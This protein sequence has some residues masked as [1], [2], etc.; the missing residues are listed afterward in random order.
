MLLSLHK[1]GGE[2]PAVYDNVV[3][4]EETGPITRAGSINEINVCFH[5]GESRLPM[6]DCQ[7][8][9]NSNDS[10]ARKDG[11]PKIGT[12]QIGRAHV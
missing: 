4:Q 12:Y 11:F 3:Q 1:S 2:I 8:R 5:S 7:F 6:G 10:V 9:V